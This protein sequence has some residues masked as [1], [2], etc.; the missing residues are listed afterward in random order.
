MKSTCLKLAGATLLLALFATGCPKKT[1]DL[2]LDA[3]RQAIDDARKKKAGDC[4]EARPQFQAAESAIAEAA[5]LSEEGDVEGAKARALEAKT[6]AEQA[7]AASRPGCGEKKEEPE[8]EE[9][10]KNVNDAS[11]SMTNLEGVMETVYFDYND[12]TIREDSKAMLS[13]VA[14]A[15]AKTPDVQIEVEGH[16]DVRGSTEYNLHLGERR[17]RSVEKYLTTAGVGPKQIQ[18]IS[19]GEERPV[20]LGDSESAHS[21]NRRA[22][23]RRMK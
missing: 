13:K 14:T 12:S 18:I 22:E 1:A 17:A 9:Q 7:S 15:L 6:L 10:D 5:R 21:K 2:E 16:C 23:L 11:A 4:D 19:Y 3:A 20:D 8:P